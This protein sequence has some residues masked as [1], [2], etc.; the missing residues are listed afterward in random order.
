MEIFQA[1]RRKGGGKKRKPGRKR[2]HACCPGGSDVCE[3]ECTTPSALASRA[4]PT[5][6]MQ[7]GPKAV[8]PKSQCEQRMRRWS[9]SCP[10]CCFTSGLKMQSR[11]GG[12]FP[13]AAA[14]ISRLWA[15]GKETQ[16]FHKTS[17][18]GLI[19]NIPG[20]LETWIPG[21]NFREAKTRRP[22]MRVSINTLCK[23]RWIK[24]LPFDSHIVSLSGAKGKG[25]VRML[26]LGDLLVPSSGELGPFTGPDWAG[27]GWGRVNFLHSS[28][29]VLETVLI[30]QGCVI[31]AKQCLH[32]A[33]AFSAPHPTSAVSGLGVHKELGGDT[34]R[35]AD[36]S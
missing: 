23:P 36:P 17:L 28:W 30:T 19:T 34:A 5:P 14:S 27:F 11:S 24:M 2:R 13:H 22:A 15:G 29:F 10:I 4:F 9:A 6:Q 35:T 12:S 32:R 18:K 21:L 26:L 31:T 1:A 8:N 25:L 33:K 16:L 20:T 7:A 3:K